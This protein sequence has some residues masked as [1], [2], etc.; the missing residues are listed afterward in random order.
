MERPAPSFVKRK[1]Q[2]LLHLLSSVSKSSVSIRC[3]ADSFGMGRDVEEAWWLKTTATVKKSHA[4]RLLTLRLSTLFHFIVGEEHDKSVVPPYEE[5]ASS[6]AGQVRS[7]DALSQGFG[8]GF[9]L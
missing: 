8:D 5:A 2:P 7:H 9:G 3:G 4:L 1:M 6:F